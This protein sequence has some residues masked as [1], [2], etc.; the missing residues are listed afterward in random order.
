M[1]FPVLRATQLRVKEVGMVGKVGRIPYQPYPCET[2]INRTLKFNTDTR[3]NDE[4]R[5]RRLE[6]RL[7]WG[8]FGDK[9]FKFRG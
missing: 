8:Y 9:P 7:S 2:Y 1:I 3:S 5:K 4:P 6:I